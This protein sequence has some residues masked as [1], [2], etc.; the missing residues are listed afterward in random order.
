MANVTLLTPFDFR[1]ERN[2]GNWLVTEGDD[3]YIAISSGPY[4]QG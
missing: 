2:Y 1:V 4:K 3:T